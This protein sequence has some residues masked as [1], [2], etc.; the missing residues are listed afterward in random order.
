MFQFKG[1]Y[2]HNVDILDVAVH[3]LHQ[4]VHLSRQ[5]ESEKVTEYFKYNLRHYKHCSTDFQQ[6]SV[7]Q[8]AM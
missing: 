2:K 3:V 4:H 1:D 7:V 5:D 6:P 8:Y